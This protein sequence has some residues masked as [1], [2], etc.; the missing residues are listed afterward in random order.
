[1]GVTSTLEG[2]EV[3]LQIEMVLHA[4]PGKAMMAQCGANLASVDAEKADIQTVINSYD[5]TGTG[6][7]ASADPHHHHGATMKLSDSL[8]EALTA[9]A[10]DMIRRLAKPR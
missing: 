10:K 6:V 9:G 3:N 8:T 1:V 7:I 2:K 5:S 4:M